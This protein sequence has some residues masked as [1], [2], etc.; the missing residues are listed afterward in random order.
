MGSVWHAGSGDEMGLAK[1]EIEIRKVQIGPVKCYLD[2]KDFLGDQYWLFFGICFVAIILA[3]VVPIFVMGPAYAGM[4]LCMTMRAR[5]EQVTF[6]TLFKGFDFYLPS[7]IVTLIYMGAVIVL[8]IPFISMLIGGIAL[9]AIENGRFI[10]IGIPVVFL[11]T[12]YWMIV[13]SIL[14]MVY[15]FAICLVVDK[16]MDGWPAMAAATKGVCLNFFGVAGTSFVG[17]AEY[18]IGAMMCFI[19]GLL[20]TPIVFT[21][22]FIAYWKI[23]GIRASDTIVADVA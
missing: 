2:A 14:I 7:L 5:G 12:A 3:G 16:K 22:H 13:L 1:S 11:A 20:V 6:E 23:F 15:T 9:V 8:A 21:G 19:P 18:F 10:L 17:Q 4:L